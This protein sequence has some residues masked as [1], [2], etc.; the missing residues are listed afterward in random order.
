[1]NP[2]SRALDVDA[3]E[4]ALWDDMTDRLTV[5]GAG[6]TLCINQVGQSFAYATV[7][8]VGGMSAMWLSPR[9]AHDSLWQAWP[10]QYPNVGVVLLAQTLVWSLATGFA[11]LA[12]LVEQR[13]RNA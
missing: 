11:A 7:A 6:F 12:Q 13:T 5:W 8:G 9:Q 10:S 4:L 1:M 2:Y 3:G